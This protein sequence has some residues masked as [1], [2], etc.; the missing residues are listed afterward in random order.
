MLICNYDVHLYMCSLYS[1]SLL[2]QKFGSSV[3]S[4]PT[5]FA[6]NR[7]K[8]LTSSK[9]PSFFLG[10][11]SVQRLPGFFRQL[12]GQPLLWAVVAAGHRLFS[13][14]TISIVLQL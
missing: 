3:L 13:N 2:R 1:Q 4:L 6:E 7:L 9:A 14:S 12:T 11:G 5:S 8:F 10:G